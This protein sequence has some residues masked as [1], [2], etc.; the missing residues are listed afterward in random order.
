MDVI[1]KVWKWGKARMGFLVIVFALYTL[2]AIIFLALWGEVAE[3]GEEK[4][5]FPIYWNW[6]WLGAV[7]AYTLASI[8][9]TGL[10]ERALKL[11]LGKPPISEEI[12][13]QALTFAPLGL[14]KLERVRIELQQ[15]ELPGEPEQIWRAKDEKGKELP[16]GIGKDNTPINPPKKMVKQ[17]GKKEK[18]EVELP[19]VQPIRVLFNKKDPV[20][21]DDPLSQT[22]NFLGQLLK[23]RPAPPKDSNRGVKNPATEAVTAEVIGVLQWRVRGTRDF[24]RTYHTFDR[25]EKLIILLDKYDAFRRR[26]KKEHKEAIELVRD[27]IRSNP[28]FTEDREFEELVNNLDAMIT[29]NKEVYESDLQ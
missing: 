2:F 27:K 11:L 16:L 9:G 24:L 26:G 18:V 17:E 13:Y 22:S 5:E 23:L 29:A 25:A 3:L 14:F 19:W 4:G 7:I 6:I 8:T 28:N 1:Q 21:A 12:P 20:E 10:N 15:I